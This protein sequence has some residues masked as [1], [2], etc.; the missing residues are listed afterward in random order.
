MTS[1]EWPLKALGGRSQRLLVKESTGACRWRDVLASYG[2]KSHKLKNMTLRKTSRILIKGTSLSRS[3]KLRKKS[4][5]RLVERVYLLTSTVPL[6]AKMGPS[7][8]LIGHPLLPTT[9]PISLSL[10]FSLIF[11]LIFILILNW[12]GIINPAPQTRSNH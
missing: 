3:R 7:Y 1:D 6:R 10:I 11:I 2:L 5:D 9:I 4:L 12:L 8:S